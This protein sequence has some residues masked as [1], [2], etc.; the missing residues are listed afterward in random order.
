MTTTTEC[1]SF[2]HEGV[3]AK[4][5][6]DTPKKGQ[7]GSRARKR[8]REEERGR[9]GKRIKRK[10]QAR[11]EEKEGKGE[12]LLTFWSKP[13]KFS[14][15]PADTQQG[16]SSSRYSPPQPPWWRWRHPLH[17]HALLLSD[18]H[19]AG[20]ANADLGNSPGKLGKTFLELLSFLGRVVFGD[21][22]HTAGFRCWP[23]HLKK[24]LMQYFLQ[25]WKEGRNKNNLS[26]KKAWEKI[27]TPVWK[28]NFGRQKIW[29]AY[30]LLWGWGN[31]WID[32][33]WVL[34]PHVLGW[35]DGH[36]RG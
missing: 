28:K 32:E 10:E 9:E 24:K 11:E 34:D 26:L 8:N 1:W 15:T 13:S 4:V 5:S 21:G 35:Q 3:V 27:C 14:N 18:L 33:G 30:K 31:R 25:I 17:H 20:S 7:R 16:H 29:K 2:P 19:L 36:L 22:V 23:F 12:N 6:I